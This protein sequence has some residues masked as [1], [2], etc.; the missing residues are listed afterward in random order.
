MNLGTSYRCLS[1]YV[2][3]NSG[4]S[5]R[6]RDHS[7]SSRTDPVPF[8][9]P[10]SPSTPSLELDR[11]HQHRTRALQQQSTLV[12]TMKGHNIQLPIDYI[13]VSHLYSTLDSIPPFS[14]L[15]FIQERM[16]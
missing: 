14:F 7:F 2:Q 13:Q 6:R 9:A 5:M 10:Q 15:V 16:Y 1:R 8:E 11:K 3:T 12:N 4:I